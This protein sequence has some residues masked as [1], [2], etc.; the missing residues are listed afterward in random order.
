MEG[1]SS[2]ALLWTT[3]EKRVGALEVC[4]AL[5]VGVEEVEGRAVGDGEVD[6][7]TKSSENRGFAMGVGGGFLTTNVRGRMVVGEVFEGSM[8]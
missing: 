4:E 5:V 8:E 1:K 7:V 6:R 2:E 3:F